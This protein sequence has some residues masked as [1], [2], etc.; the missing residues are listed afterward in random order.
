MVDNGSTDDWK[1]TIPREVLSKITVVT[2]DTKAIQIKGYNSFFPTLQEK[3]SKDWA[4]VVDLDEYLF[5]K[6]PETIASYLSTVSDDV[7]QVR[8][9]WYVNVFSFRNFD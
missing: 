6:P 4:L 8:I 9:P 1:S 3:H 2:D 5:A 7:G